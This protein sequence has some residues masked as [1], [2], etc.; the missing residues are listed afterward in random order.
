MRFW[1]RTVFF[2]FFLFS[3]RIH[4]KKYP[5]SSDGIHPKNNCNLKSELTNCDSFCFFF[6]FFCNKHACKLC[7]NQTLNKNVQYNHSNFKVTLKRRPLVLWWFCIYNLQGTGGFVFHFYPQ[8]LIP[9]P[10][11]NLRSSN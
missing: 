11:Y 9:P 7:F 8:V 2:L 3:S 6:S 10:F 5:F 4:T 1:N